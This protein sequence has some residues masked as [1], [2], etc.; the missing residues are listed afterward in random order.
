MFPNLS[1]LVL[2]PILTHKDGE[3]P[4]PFHFIRG[5][6]G[7]LC[8]HFRVTS[9]EDNEVPSSRGSSFHLRPSRLAVSSRIPSDNCIFTPMLYHCAISDRVH[10]RKHQYSS[11]S[12]R[13]IWC[14][15]HRT[16]FLSPKRIS[17]RT[18]TSTVLLPDILG[19]SLHAMDLLPRFTPA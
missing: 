14:L 3:E 15:A 1:V 18:D 2:E 16:S 6:F 10:A 9:A 11:Q 12:R 4:Q 5:A 7:I 17:T 19:L 13:G 8:P